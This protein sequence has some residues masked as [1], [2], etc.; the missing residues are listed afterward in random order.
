MCLWSF[1]LTFNLVM[2]IITEKKVIMDLFLL[3]LI[4]MIFMIFEREIRKDG[5]CF[6]FNMNCFFCKDVVG[7]IK[8]ICEQEVNI[9]LQNLIKKS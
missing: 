2:C 4:H 3:I 9:R 8:V 5:F 6:I 7:E 1:L